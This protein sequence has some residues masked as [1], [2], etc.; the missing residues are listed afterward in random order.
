MDA[1]IIGRAALFLG[2]GRAR[3]DDAIDFAVGFSRIKKFGESVEPNEP[4]LFVHA[5]TDQALA[6]VLPLL[7]KAI[8]V[9]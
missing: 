5:R 7:E 1:A 3:S 6:S 8:E 9:A 2:A 4:L